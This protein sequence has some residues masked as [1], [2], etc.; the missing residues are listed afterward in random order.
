MSDYNTLLKELGLDVALHDEMIKA[1]DRLF[2]ETVGAQK[3]RP[4]EM[5]YFDRVL[6]EAHGARVAE[7]VEE[8]RN[9]KRIVGTFCIYVPEELAL[10]ANTVP[11]ALCGGIQ[12]SIPY[13]ERMFP[14]DICPLVKSTLGLAFSKTCPYA[15]I[16]SLA[17]GETTCDAKKKTWEILAG[18]VNFHVMEVPQ[19]KEKLDFDLWR[20]AVDDFRRKL[21]DLSGTKVDSG[22]L[23]ETIRIMNAKRRALQELAQL[24]QAEVVPISGVDA[25]VVMQAA[26]NDEPVR[27]TEAVKRLNQELRERIK[28]GISVA[29]GAKRIMM[30]GCPA[31]MGN[32]K[33]HA[34]VERSG[35]VIVWDESCTGSRY[36]EHLVDETAQDLDG[37]ITAIAERY[38]KISCACFTPNQERI[39]AIVRRAQEFNV[40]GV[41]QYVL[42]TCHGYNI[43]AMR[44][45]AA[46]KGIGVPALKVVT[47]YSEEDTEQL[48]TR[49]EAFI[50]QL[51]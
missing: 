39:D 43:E 24:R 49:I 25:L 1:T 18:K 6:A 23:A 50:E 44:V 36:F 13:A 7:L 15:P 41:V 19:K 29:P 46:L 34:L 40:K 16:K 32:W 27:F 38:F 11:I 14:R 48:R 28:N 3:N 17:V 51:A 45:E 42:Q 12:A 30:A 47:D 2:Q 5:A 9:G 20:E 22:R 31:V 26:L 10:A 4:K 35:G 21:E 37:Q 8:K 33:V